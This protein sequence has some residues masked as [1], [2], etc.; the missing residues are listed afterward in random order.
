MELWLTVVSSNSKLARLPKYCSFP[1]LV[2]RDAII[3]YRGTSPLRFF[4][5]ISS[6]WVISSSHTKFQLSTRCRS[7]FFIEVV[8]WVAG[9]FRKYNHFVVELASSIL[10]RFQLSWNSQVQPECG[11]IKFDTLINK[12]QQLSYF[13]LWR[14]LATSSDLWRQ[15][16]VYFWKD[17]EKAF[18]M[19][20]WS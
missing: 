4:L 18:K 19:S 11:N 8:G 7:Q 17:T 20:Y 2:N 6:R 9:S 10:A 1:A 3:V 15:K 16:R 14:P 13:D 12:I 5:H